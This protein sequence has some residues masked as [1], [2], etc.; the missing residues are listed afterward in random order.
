MRPVLAPWYTVCA[1]LTTLSHTV[2]CIGEAFGVDPNDQAQVE[3]L[4]VKPANLLSIFDVFLKTKDKLASPSGSAAAAAPS[5]PAAP[6]AADKAAAEK[7][8]ATGNAQM[9]SKKYDD[10]IKSY[11][12][13]IAL[14]PTNAV[15][16]SNRAAAY[17]SK[18]EHSSAVLD[19]EKAIEADPSFVK[20]YHRLGCVCPRTSSVPSRAL[21][22]SDYALPDTHTIP[23]VTSR[24]PQKHSAVASM[25]IP[26]MLRSRL[27]SQ[28]QK[29]VSF[30]RRTSTICPHLSPHPLGVVPA[31]MWGQAQAVWEA[32]P[33]CFATWAWAAVPAVR[34]EV[35]AEACP[36]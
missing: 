17:S 32:W 10:A 8:K 14:D 16:Y 20:A 24:Q 11:T 33:T 27:A 35:R 19:A 13:A 9:S 15:Y 12:Q 4:S 21:T 1:R 26:T 29:L 25:L 6:S 36:T 22:T 18:G 30:R 7:L 34:E 3:R 28:T 2:Q 5:A 23:L 31:P